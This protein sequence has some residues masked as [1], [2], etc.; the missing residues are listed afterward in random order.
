MQSHYNDIY[1]SLL[2][3]SIHK[4]YA[5]ISF[6]LRIRELLVI[7]LLLT[8]ADMQVTKLSILNVYDAL[9]DVHHDVHH[10]IDHDVDHDVDST[11]FL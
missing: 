11:Y 9:Y 3:Q 8:S 7:Y 4:K 2:L 5:P 1:Y 10:D 6:C